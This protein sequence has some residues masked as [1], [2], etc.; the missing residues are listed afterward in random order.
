[1]SGE[2]FFA[3][4]SGEGVSAADLI[5]EGDSSEG[6]DQ[7]PL[8]ATYDATAAV[9]RRAKNKASS[10][11]YFDIETVPDQSRIEQ[12]GLPDLPT[13][14]DCNIDD[15]D[16]ESLLGGTVKDIEEFLFQDQPS[17]DCVRSLAKAERGGKNRKG[18]LAAMDRCRAERER[19]LDSG[20]DRNK[21]LSVTPEYCRIVAL[22]MGIGG[23]ET[24]SR[25]SA[26]ASDAAE[27]T[28]LR[29]FWE[30]AANFSPLV[31]FNV[32]HFDLPV[33]FVRSMIL[34]VQPTRTIDLKPWSADVVDLYVRRFGTRGNTGKGPGKLKD[35][36]RLHGI[37]V[38]AG[39]TDGGDV[40]ALLE[41]DPEK[42]GEYVRSDVEITRKLHLQYQ[43]FFC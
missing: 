19:A 31:G 25:I 9:R 12:F 40:L 20:A 35:L 29:A 6:N 22:G 2:D 33:I 10:F 11:L 8:R 15:A 38:P 23:D 34:G 24:D 16:T 14:A 13:W 18:V 27:K 28:I 4:L 43:G 26:D 30:A 7:M 36:A 1:M 3:G 42:L 39:D 21:L 37:E 5:E 32:L 17:E 41:S